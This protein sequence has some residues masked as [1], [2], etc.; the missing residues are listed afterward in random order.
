MND[1]ETL[2]VGKEEILPGVFRMLFES[3]RLVSLAE[4]GQFVLLVQG[5]RHE[6][7]FTAPSVT[8]LCA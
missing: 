1:H 3:P 5:F 7:Q 6:L 4:P 2:L 8:V